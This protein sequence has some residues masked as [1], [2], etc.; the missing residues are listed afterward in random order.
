MWTKLNEMM[1]KHKFPKANFKIFMANNAQANWNI[2]KIVYGFE[3]PYV[4]MVDKER[5][6]LFHWNH[7]LDKHTKQLIRPDVQDEH[8]VFCHQYKNAKLLGELDSHYVL[9][10]F[11]WLSFGAT[12]EVGVHELSNWFNFWHFRVKQW[13]GFMVHVSTSSVNFPCLPFSYV[14]SKL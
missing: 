9:I 3:D 4:R 10:H 5:T 11:W 8:K 14:H 2:V 12:F 1:L 6:Y 7:S 13:G